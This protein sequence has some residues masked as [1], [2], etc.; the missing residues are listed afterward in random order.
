MGDDGAVFGS[1]E[2]V[3]NLK[4]ETTDRAAKT[5]DDRLRR[6]KSYLEQQQ[7]DLDKSELDVDKTTGALLDP[8]VQAEFAKFRACPYL[9]SS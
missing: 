9:N 2:W 3:R 4:K 8:Q 7:H 1:K 5:F 6:L